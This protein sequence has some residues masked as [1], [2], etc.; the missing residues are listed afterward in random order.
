VITYWQAFGIVILAKLIFGGI[1]GRSAH[2]HKAPGRGGPHDL[3]RGRDNWRY[4]REFWEQEGKAAFDRFV[5]RHEGAQ[6]P[7]GEPPATGA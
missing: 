6:K 1:G 3:P 5:E 2:G 4:Y 7:A